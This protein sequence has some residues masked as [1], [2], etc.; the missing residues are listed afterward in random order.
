MIRQ[1]WLRH[2]YL[3]HRLAVAYRSCRGGE[4]QKAALLLAGPFSSIE[5]D[6]VDEFADYASARLG[7]RDKPKTQAEA[8]CG[9][10]DSLL[11]LQV[12]PLGLYRELALRLYQRAI[13]THSSP[14]WTHVKIAQLYLRRRFG[15]REED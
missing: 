13:A 15:A 5:P 2:L 7:R 1:R 3:R 8:L 4:Q 12:G 9:V 14:E 10:A 11:S 6:D